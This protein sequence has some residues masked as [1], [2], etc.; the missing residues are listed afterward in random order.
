[1]PNQ[2]AR[3]KNEVKGEDDIQDHPSTYDFLMIF[4][5]MQSRVQICME[6]RIL[7][8]TLGIQ[9]I[10][11]IRGLASIMLYIISV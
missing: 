7:I 9:S 11:Y 6:N 3:V 4:L 5:K 10:T 8:M 1:M 2:Y